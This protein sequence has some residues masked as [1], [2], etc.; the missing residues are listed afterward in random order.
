V[1]QRIEGVP[2]TSVFM[3]VNKE[4]MADLPKV[5]GDADRSKRL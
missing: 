2:G 5:F 1:A 3:T 4:D